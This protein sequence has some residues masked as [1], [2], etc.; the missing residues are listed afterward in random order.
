V[1][2]TGVPGQ[3]VVDRRGQGGTARYRQRATLAEIFLY[4][5][6]DQRPHAT[7]LA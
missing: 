4:V 3:I 7:T 6:D 5:D 2:V 1:P